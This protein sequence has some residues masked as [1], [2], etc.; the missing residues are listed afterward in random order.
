[1]IGIL[2]SIVLIVILVFVV[3]TLL[4]LDS[5]GVTQ[6]ITT[7]TILS[8]VVGFVVSLLSL[9]VSFL[10]WHQSKAALASEEIIAASR[11]HSPTLGTGERPQPDL[12]LNDTW[13]KS[14]EKKTPLPPAGQ[15]SRRFDWG[16]LHTWISC[17][18][19]IRNLLH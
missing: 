18:D 13:E 7:L 16:K 1:M 10:Q 19:V 9:L 17:M 2:V 11:G 12:F 3:V 8:I 14:L 15:R 4:I 6:G 5:Q